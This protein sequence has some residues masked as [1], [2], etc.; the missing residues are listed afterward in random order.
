MGSQP[1]ADMMKAVARLAHFMVTRAEADLPDVFA[2]HGVVIVENFAPHVFHGPTAVRD[3]AAG[4]RAHAADLSELNPTF[5]APQDFSCD[6]ERAYLSLPTR[7]TGISRG[8]R[9]VED[10][11]WS[12]VLLRD[13][14]EWRVQAY[15]WA[16]T[17]YSPAQQ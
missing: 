5:G 13:G 1:D 15:G 11:G 17:S 16:V 7:W 9:F 3:W 8:R 14:A 4:F 2:D 10:G 6:G 12:F